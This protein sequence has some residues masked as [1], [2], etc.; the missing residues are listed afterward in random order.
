MKR[1]IHSPTSDNLIQM[2]VAIAESINQAGGY[3]ADNTWYYKTAR[4]IYI[5]ERP[6]GLLL[7]VL[8]NG[9][10]TR[11]GDPKNL[12]VLCPGLSDI[13]SDFGFSIVKQYKRYAGLSEV[14]T[15]YALLQYD[16]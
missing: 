9:D 2:K 12:S 4:N 16:N 14:T 11:Y 15:Y 8:M 1:Y 6:N 13:L 10:W 3:T 5:E 7:Y